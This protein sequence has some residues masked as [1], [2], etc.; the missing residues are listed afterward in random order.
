MFRAPDFGEMPRRLFRRLPVK[1]YPMNDYLTTPAEVI[2]WLRGIAAAQPMF[3]PVKW[4]EKSYRF[5]QVDADADIQ[6]DHYQPTVVP[7]VKLLAPARDE[8]LRFTRTEDGHT[9]VQATVD[10]SPRVIAG[11]RPCDLKGIFLM[12]LFFSDGVE[13]P[14]YMTRRE[15][16][17]IIGHAC[18]SPCDD[19]VFCAAVDSL[20]HR[21]G[22]DIF[23]TPV[24]GGD[25]LVEAISKRGAALLE[26]AEFTPCADGPARKVGAVAARQEPYGRSW[27]AK[28]SELPAIIE[29]QWKSPVWEKHVTRCFSCGTCNLVCPT[30]YCFDVADDLNLDVQSG[31]RVRTWDACMLPHFAQ[32]AGGH[33][34]RPK[35]ADRQRHRV[36]RK[37]EYLTR[38]YDHGAVC[39]GC[40]RCGRQCTSKIDIFD[41]VDDLTK[42]GA[43]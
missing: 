39:V 5:R 25:V 9:D 41:I 35:P 38:K 31:N 32:V 7:P 34:F 14:H 29:R 16:T 12:D 28:V 42:E 8:L 15:N 30:C 13:D 23:L 36:K 40:G 33:N 43:E 2:Q 11:V 19:R 37:F 24:K 26:G 18:S 17:V 20:D 4:G 27:A 3:F 21:T 22:A 6:F 1:G 10:T